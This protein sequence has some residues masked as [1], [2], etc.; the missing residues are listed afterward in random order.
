MVRVVYDPKVISLDEVL[1]TF[2]E[3][4]DPTQINRQGN[5]VGTQYRSAIYWSDPADE[6][7]VRASA[8]MFDAA[9]VKAGR[10]R[11]ATELK[12]NDTFYYAEEYHQQYLHKVPWGYC[13]L[14]G[15]G[16]SCPLPTGVKSDPSD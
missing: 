14:Q 10:N 6:T 7:A 4:H 5:D 1:R 8:A 16:V 15:T 3:E 2:W 9:L 12:F 13:G 11:V